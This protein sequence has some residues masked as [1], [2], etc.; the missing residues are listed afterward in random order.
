M[1]RVSPWASR[2]SA[3]EVNPRT[4]Q[5][6]TLKLRVS[7][8]RTSW[9]GSSASRATT[10]GAAQRANASRTGERLFDY[11]GMDLNTGDRGVDRRSALIAQRQRADADHHNA[12]GH[13]RGIDRA[14]KHLPSGKGAPRF[15]A[16][17]ARTELGMGVG[18]DLDLAG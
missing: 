16:R 1:K 5:N 10:A 17:E 8:P 11:W 2:R 13:A 3:S 12:S 4:S 15:G 18:R 6:M 14:G 9:P 7:P